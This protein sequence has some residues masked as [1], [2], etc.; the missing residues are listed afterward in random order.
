VEVARGYLGEFAVS[1]S[2]DLSRALAAYTPAPD[3]VEHITGVPP[4]PETLAYVAR[5]KIGDFNRKKDAQ[6]RCR[7]IPAV[8]LAGP[9]FRTTEF[10]CPANPKLCAQTFSHT[11][12]ANA[13]SKAAI[14][15]APDDFHDEF[16]P[17]GDQP[18]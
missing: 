5:S 6:R 13:A 16:I 8:P 3:R 9:E 4:Y 15:D 12:S 7:Q 14:S 2:Q 10:S 11:P 17:S 1:L 18:E